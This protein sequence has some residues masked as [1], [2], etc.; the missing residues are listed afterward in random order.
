MSK[1]GSDDEKV[2]YCRPP[3]RHQ[4]R[5]GQSG[6]PAGRKKGSKNFETI[7]Q[8][9]MN[10]AV[11]VNDGGERRTISRLQL[12]VRVL[13]DQAAQGKIAACRELMRLALPVLQASAEVGSTPGGG[14]SLE[15]PDE[16]FAEMLQALTRGQD[17]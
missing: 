5:K 3:K 4:Y 16:F 15:I 9:E 10:R 12:I 13:S 17:Q 6:N 8:D 7:I 14:D 11:T 1:N 2:G